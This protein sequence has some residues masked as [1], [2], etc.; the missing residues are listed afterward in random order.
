VKTLEE[1]RTDR[2][3]K[4]AE[5]DAIDALIKVELSK[6]LVRCESSN[7]GLGCGMAMEVRELTFIQTHWYES[8]H[9]CN[10]GDM[11]HRGEGNFKCLHCGRR[12]RLHNRKA[13]EQLRDHFKNVVEE[14]DK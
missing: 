6:T 12:N 2:A 7:Y 9:G 13:I 10:G 1:L 4:K 14:H 3:A 5:L 8:P 11:W